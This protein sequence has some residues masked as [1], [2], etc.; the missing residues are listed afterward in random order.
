MQDKKKDQ[1]L[2]KREREKR[3]DTVKYSDKNNPLSKLK[4]GF[5]TFF[6]AVFFC[7]LFVFFVDFY[8]ITFFKRWLAK[9]KKVNLVGALRVQSM[10][11]ISTEQTFS[12]VKCLSIDLARKFIAYIG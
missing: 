4:C 5:F 1:Q 8:I 9:I 7:W 10:F 11:Q 12:L 2:S 3:K 6:I